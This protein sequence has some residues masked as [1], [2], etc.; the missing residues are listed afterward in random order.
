ML[1]L[2]V[3]FYSLITFRVQYMWLEITCTSLL[4][5]RCSYKCFYGCC[6]GKLIIKN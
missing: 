3:T 4:F 2:I 1:F 6:I 5:L